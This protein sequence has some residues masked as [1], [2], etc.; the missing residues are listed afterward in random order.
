MRTRKYWQ[1]L[2]LEFLLQTCLSGKET[3][4]AS[5]YHKDSYKYWAFSSNIMIRNSLTCTKTTHLLLHRSFLG[6][7]VA[8]VLVQEIGIQPM[9]FVRMRNLG[10]PIEMMVSV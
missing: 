6:A 2:C 10:C 9:T 1:V 4:V 3:V 8:G 7:V 5:A